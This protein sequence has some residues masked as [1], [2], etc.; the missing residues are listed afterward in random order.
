[1]L[2]DKFIKESSEMGTG[3]EWEVIGTDMER[4]F[5]KGIG[6]MTISFHLGSDSR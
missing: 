1:M 3:M 4:W 5:V 6:R 2:M